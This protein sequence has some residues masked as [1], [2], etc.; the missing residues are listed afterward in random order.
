G[1]EVLLVHVAAVPVAGARSAVHAHAAAERELAATVGH[2][3]HHGVKARS[4]LRE[5]APDE[6]IV[7][8]AEA[9]RADLI[10]VRTHGRTG[11]AHA[12]LGSVAERVV[13]GTPCPVLTVGR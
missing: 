10:V 1:A 7:A 12:L 13:R 9:E 2:L 4:L 5:G 8:A 3:V 6:E 11:L